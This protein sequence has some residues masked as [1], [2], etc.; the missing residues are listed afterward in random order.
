M[1]IKGTWFIYIYTSNIKN[2]GTDAKVS[3]QIIGTK[4]MSNKIQLDKEENISNKDLFET[5]S[6][7][8]FVKVFSDVGKPAKIKIGHDNS[9]SFA[10]WH[11]DKV[12]LNSYYIVILLS[13]NY[14]I[15]GDITTRV[16]TR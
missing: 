10:G 9:G 16:N 6:C 13:G 7:D 8:K 11:L 2:A 15:K 3:I 1:I 12:L 14:C 5:G 4:G